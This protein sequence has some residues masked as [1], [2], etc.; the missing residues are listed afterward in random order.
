[1]SKGIA[2]TGQGFDI[3]GKRLGGLSRQPPLSSLRAT[4]ATAAE[5]RVRAGTLLP[6][7]PHRLGGDCSIMSDL[8]PIQAAAMA[9]ERRLLDDIWCG[10]Q[11]TEGLEDE[12][13]DSETCKEPISVRVKDFT[14]LNAKSVKRC[15]SW[16]NASSG[17]QC[18]SDVIDLTEEAPETRCTKRSCSSGDQG[19]S[20]SKDE[21][22]SGFMKSSVTFPLTSHNA[23]HSSEESSMWECAECTLLNPVSRPYRVYVFKY[24]LEASCYLY[25][26]FHY[27]SCFL[28]PVI[29]SNM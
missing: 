17:P 16:S 12:E 23:N 20:C 29:G 7:G 26:V 15:S 28:L 4:S 8:S 1:M 21:P 22:N 9:A 10:S 13:D 14:T 19:P 18:G 25:S 6:S 3:P 24:K 5:K 27:M 11:S 2:G